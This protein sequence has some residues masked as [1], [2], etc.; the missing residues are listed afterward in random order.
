V[1]RS[2]NTIWKILRSNDRILVDRRRRPKPLERREPLQEIQIDFKDNSTVPTDPLG[3]QQ[4]VVETCNFVDAGTS[5]WLHAPVREDFT[6]ETAL[7]VV[8]EFLR[9]YGLPPMLTFDRDPRWVGSASGRDF[10]S[11]FVRF[12]LG[13]GIQPH[14]CPPHRPDTNAFVERLHRTYKEEWRLLH[15][16]GTLHQVREVTEVFMAHYNTERPL[17]AA[18]LWQCPA[19][20]RLPHL[21]HAACGA[22]PGRS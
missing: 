16:P 2:T 5:I 13:L 1:P 15:R 20:R 18:L 19:A 11:A 4:H 7:E 21:A 12:R 3:K 22:C 8:A 9:Q 6:A 14:I 17:K 10:P